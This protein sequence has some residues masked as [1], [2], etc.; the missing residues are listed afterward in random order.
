ML[1]PELANAQSPDKITTTN[2]HSFCPSC[3]PTNCAK[4]TEINNKPRNSSDNITLS[5]VEGKLVHA[6]IAT[7]SHKPMNKTTQRILMK[8]NTRI[9][10]N[11]V[12]SIRRRISPCTSCSSHS[13]FAA[14]LPTSVLQLRGSQVSLR[15]ITAPLTSAL[16]KDN[17]FSANQLDSC[18]GGLV[19]LASD[20][21]EVSD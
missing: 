9:M 19:Q 7:I 3:C 16:R 15:F 10:N 14:I 8:Q 2:I 6:Y 21:D 18:N 11:E 13:P 17:V 4:S 5:A 12:S 1:S 20:D